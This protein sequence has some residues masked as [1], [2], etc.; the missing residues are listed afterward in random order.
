MTSVLFYSSQGR[1]TQPIKVCTNQFF[2][3]SR[4]RSYPLLV[5]FIL[6]APWLQFNISVQT[7]VQSHYTSIQYTSFV[8]QKKCRNNYLVLHLGLS[9]PCNNSYSHLTFYLP[10]WLTP[11]ILIFLCPKY[12]LDCLWRTPSCFLLLNKDAIQGLQIRPLLSLPCNFH[13]F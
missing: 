13:S 6:L 8:V 7:K 5:G 12:F 11:V 10:L 9:P 2:S 4:R 1:N 3:R